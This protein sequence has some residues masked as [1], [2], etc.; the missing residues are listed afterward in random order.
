MSSKRSFV[1]AFQGPSDTGLSRSEVEGYQPVSRIGEVVLNAFVDGYEWNTLPEEGLN[2]GDI[3][4][5]GDT[6]AGYE[7]KPHFH[8]WASVLPGMI[9]V[10]RKA[11]N[12]TFRNYAA[13]ETAVPVIGC[14][15]GLKLKDQK[16]YYFAGVGDDSNFNVEC[17]STYTHPLLHRPLLVC[18]QGS[19]GPRPSASSTTAAVPPKTNFSPSSS[20]G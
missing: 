16:D 1:Q 20:V 3:E 18:L 9:C 19:A 14:A 4:G 8:E 6:T 11:R 17:E 7:M 2:K 15:A 13:A 10:S 5:S 12:S